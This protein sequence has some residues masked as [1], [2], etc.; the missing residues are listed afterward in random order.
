[1][2]L[3]VVSISPQESKS[4]HLRAGQQHYPLSSYSPAIQRLRHDTAEIWRGAI[5]AEDDG[6]FPEA[7]K[8]R[9]FVAPPLQ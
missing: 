9:N 8:I 2:I 6:A 1:M 3:T 7:V 5:L 4:Y